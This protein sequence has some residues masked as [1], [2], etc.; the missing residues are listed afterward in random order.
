MRPSSPYPPLTSAEARA[1]YAAA[2]SPEMRRALWEIRRLQG[3]VIESE[4]LMD[5]REWP[6]LQ[7]SIVPQVAQWRELL[8]TE[9]CIVE[10]RARNRAL[11]AD[12]DRP[13]PRRHLR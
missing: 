7:A 11:A 2:P 10:L 1:L 6:S 4:R 5:L 9:P 13:L 3:L 8:R 12:L